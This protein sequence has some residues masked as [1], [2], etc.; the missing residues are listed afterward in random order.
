MRLLVSAYRMKKYP[1]MKRHLYLAQKV[2]LDSGMISAWK[3]Q[4]IAWMDNQDYVVELG[5]EIKADYIAM[6]D[7][8]SEPH[9]LKLNDFTVAQAMEVTIRNAEAFIR[10]KTQ[11]TK[12]F[13]LQGWLLSDYEKCIH[14]Y[15]KLGIF[16]LDNIWVGLGTC[17]MR[18]PKADGGRQISFIETVPG[19]YEVARFVRK[20]LPDH[21]LHAFGIGKPEWIGELL[22]IGINSFDSANGSIM[23]GFNQGEVR[24]KGKRD[25]QI[26][27]KQYV[28]A[29]KIH[30][31]KVWEVW[32]DVLPASA[33]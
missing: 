6:L 18:R 15:R 23:A 8:P 1:R 7:L 24:V 13:V 22:K 29:M 17:C 31:R 11:A 5:N 3:K 32:F 4:D 20:Q 27:L 9:L 12:V 33:F 26:I 2:F 10:A 14:A 16:A 25:T 21:H 28:D 30:Q 19:L